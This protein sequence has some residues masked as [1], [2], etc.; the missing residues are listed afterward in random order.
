M[1]FRVGGHDPTHVTH[2]LTHLILTA[3]VSH[4]YSRHTANHSI[5]NECRNEGLGRLFIGMRY[6]AMTQGHRGGKCK[7]CKS[8]SDLSLS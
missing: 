2:T 8:D 4:A 3:A 5:G 7:N 6:R 1:N